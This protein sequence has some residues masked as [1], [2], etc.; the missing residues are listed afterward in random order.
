MSRPGAVLL[1]VLL[2]TTACK[3]ANPDRSLNR[4]DLERDVRV[5]EVPVRGSLV[6]VKRL[7]DKDN[8]LV[9]ELLGVDEEHLWLRVENKELPVPRVDVQRVELELYPSKAG[10]TGI[11]TGLGTA[12]TLSHGYFLVFSAPIWLL[13]GITSSVS[14]SKANTV[15]LEPQ[16]LD[17]LRQYARFPQGM[18]VTAPAPSPT[19]PPA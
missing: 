2:A 11:W 10:D 6:T 3:T 18:P 7:D 12:S 5:D 9:G 17:L 15:V 19:E 8:K 13:T 4:G 16:E 14:A 1:T